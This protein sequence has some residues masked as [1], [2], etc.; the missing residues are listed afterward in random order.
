MMI[1]VQVSPG[2]VSECDLLDLNPAWEDNW[3]YMYHR[4]IIPSFQVNI[5]T[6][7]LV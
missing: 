7:E 4:G 2:N 3:P 5:N 6:I 1:T